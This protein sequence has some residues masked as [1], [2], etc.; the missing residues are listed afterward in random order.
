MKYFKTEEFACPCCG[1]NKMEPDFCN[2]LDNARGYAGVAFCLNSGYR[3]QKHNHNV[4]S[5]KT[6]SHPKGCAGDIAA[7][8]SKKRYKIIMGLLAAGF[9]RI[10]I[11]RTFIHVDSDKEKPGNVIWTY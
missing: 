3:C 8:T 9:N 10:G 7:R 2:K 4:G 5:K 6:S 1:Q 11:A